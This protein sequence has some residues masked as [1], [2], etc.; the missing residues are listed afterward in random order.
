MVDDGSN[1]ETPALLKNYAKMDSRF[2]LFSLEKNGGVGHARN[3]ALRQASGEWIAS[4]DADDWYLPERLEKLL[5]A[6]R[7][8]KADAVIENLRIFD[9]ATEKICAETAF[10]KKKEPALLTSLQLFK[11]DT[12]F[13]RYAIG[14]A[15]PFI[16]AS[17]LKESCLYYDERFCLGEDFVFLAEAVLKGAKFF[18]LPFSSY[19]HVRRLSPSQGSVSPFSHSSDDHEQIVL[20]SRILCARYENVSF[21]TRLAM[22]KRLYLFG[23]LVQA[24]ALKTLWVSRK[25]LSFFRLFLLRPDV[26]LFSSI[27]LFLKWAWRFL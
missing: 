18:I 6:A 11:K 19:V 13:S 25:R 17:F 9:H 5:S 24:R 27:S 12:P 7:A 15:R 20:A 26:L 22:K 1:D 3:H 8:L 16:K 14:Y 21:L 23:L 10:G 2:R 4:L